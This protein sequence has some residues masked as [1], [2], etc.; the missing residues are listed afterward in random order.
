MEM[1]LQFL[2]SRKPCIFQF[3]SGLIKFWI[4]IIEKKTQY[5]ILCSLENNELYSLNACPCYKTNAGVY[6]G[7][8]VTVRILVSIDYDDLDY[9]CVNISWEVY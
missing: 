1:N 9:Q 7:F 2:F 5:D 8:D 3:Y 4:E 6:V